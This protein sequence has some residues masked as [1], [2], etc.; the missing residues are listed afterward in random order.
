MT[1]RQSDSAALN[2]PITTGLGAVLVVCLDN[3]DPAECRKGPSDAPL[4]M[5]TATASVRRPDQLAHR[6]AAISLS[7]QPLGLQSP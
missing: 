7:D 4:A 6:V 5:L 2:I 1:L 3:V